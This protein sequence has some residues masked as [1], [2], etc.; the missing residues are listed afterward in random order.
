MTDQTAEAL[1]HLGNL[2]MR[3]RNDALARGLYEE[4]LATWRALDDQ[5]GIAHLIE[6]LERL[7]RKQERTEVPGTV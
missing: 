4:G 3:Q 7:T 2:A 6:R 5:P 1:T